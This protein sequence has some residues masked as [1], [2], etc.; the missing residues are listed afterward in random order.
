MSEKRI[1]TY[2]AEIEDNVG[3]KEKNKI[4][5][6]AERKVENAINT[7][8]GNEHGIMKVQLQMHLRDWKGG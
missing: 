1:I 6:D 2:E 8:H 3:N 5:S 7:D 4:E